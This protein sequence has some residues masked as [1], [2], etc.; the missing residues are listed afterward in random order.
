MI[1]TPLQKLSKNVGDLGKLIAAKGLKK[2]PKVKKNRP[3]WSHCLQGKWMV[4]G[5][6]NNLKRCFILQKSFFKLTPIWLLLFL[7]KASIN[8]FTFWIQI[9]SDPYVFEDDDDSSVAFV[10][11]KVFFSLSNYQQ[12]LQQ[13]KYLMFYYFLARRILR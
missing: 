2:L 9:W 4:I 3:I 10:S 13:Q 6:L 1:F 12:I 8:C 7:A 11:T 5:F